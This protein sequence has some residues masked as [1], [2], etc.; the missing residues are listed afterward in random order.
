MITGLSMGHR[1]PQYRGSLYT[2]PGQV[3]HSTQQQGKGQAKATARG[4]VE[5]TLSIY[6]L[7]NLG[8][9]GDR[10]VKMLSALER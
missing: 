10:G 4:S 9:I 3:G 6:P 5:L 1:A 8:R 2:Q 7:N